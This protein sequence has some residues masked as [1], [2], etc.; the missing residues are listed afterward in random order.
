MEKIDY[1]AIARDKYTDQHSDDLAFDAIV[2]SMINQLIMNQDVIFDL[3]NLIYDIDLS[4]GSFLD[5][6][7]YLVGQDRVINGSGEFF[8]FQQDVSALGFGEINNPDS[9]GYWYSLSSDSKTSATLAKDDLYRRLIKARI[10]FNN[11]LGT[12]ETLLRILNL[13]SNTT[14]STFTEDGK[15]NIVINIDSDNDNLVTHFLS[16][17]ETNK[18][19]I[20]IPLGVS[21]GLNIRGL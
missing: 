3:E 6:I 12:P 14:T 20:P 8:G 19:L 5:L 1:L 15:G 7:G 4:N 11:N 21:V 18:N 9:G 13:L 17:R 10:I 16:I 2:Q